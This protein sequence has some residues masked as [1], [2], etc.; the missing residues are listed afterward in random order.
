MLS[1]VLRVNLCLSQVMVENSDFTPSQVGCLFTFLA[2]QLAKP[3][4]TLFVNRKLFDQVKKWQ[5]CVLCTC[6]W[7]SVQCVTCVHS[8]LGSAGFGVSLQSWWWLQTYRKTTSNGLLHLYLFTLCSS[9]WF[10]CNY[11]TIVPQ[12]VLCSLFL[13]CCWSCSMLGGWSNLMNRGS[14][15][16]LRRQSCEYHIWCCLYLLNS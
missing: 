7:K 14:S 8:E 4:N 5:G 10:L 12:L 15:A 6:M 9:A 16:W 1:L 3:D 2:R 13:R 11:G